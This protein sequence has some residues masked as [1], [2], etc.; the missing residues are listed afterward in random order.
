MMVKA[1]VVGQ[2]VDYSSVSWRN[3]WRE[4]ISFSIG[5]ILKEE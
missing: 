2:S 5:I 3:R 1:H 4:G